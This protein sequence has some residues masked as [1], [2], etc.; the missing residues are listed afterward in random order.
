MMREIAN[1]MQNFTRQMFELQTVAGSETNADIP[2]L[3]ASSDRF[4]EY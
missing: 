2:I 1:Q 4:P 3:T